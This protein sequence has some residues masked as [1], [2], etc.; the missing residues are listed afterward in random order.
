MF[1]SASERVLSGGG[2]RLLLRLF[3]SG[4]KKSRVTVGASESEG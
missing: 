3:G 1:I 2:G 4:E